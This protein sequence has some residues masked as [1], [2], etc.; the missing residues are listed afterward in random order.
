M[1]KIGLKE[2]QTVNYQVPFSEVGQLP[3][4]K[5]G[6]GLIWLSILSTI[7][8]WGSAAAFIYVL[9]WCL[10]HF[11]ILNRILYDF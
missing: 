1:N 2:R 11:G 4:Q 5:S 8:K 9:L 7:I 10:N 3:K 6:A